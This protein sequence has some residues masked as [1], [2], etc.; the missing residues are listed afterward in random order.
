MGA[1]GVFFVWV[2]KHLT[3]ILLTNLK[4]LLLNSFPLNS[5]GVVFVYRLI[6][7]LLLYVQVGG[8]QCVKVRNL[9]ITKILFVTYLLSHCILHIRMF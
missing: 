4:L 6:M 9:P 7:V 3:G 1:G 5:L 2:P 8:A